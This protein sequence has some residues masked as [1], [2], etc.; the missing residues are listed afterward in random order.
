MA[1]FSFPSM[2]SGDYPQWDGALDIKEGTNVENGR[3][4]ID[5]SHITM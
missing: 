3:L 4:V 5:Y 1:I 2:L